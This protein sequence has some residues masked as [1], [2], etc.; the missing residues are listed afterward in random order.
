MKYENSNRKDEE[1]MKNPILAG[2]LCVLAAGIL[3]VYGGG[4]FYYQSHFVK[5][6]V[7]DQVDVSG[8]TIPELEEQVQEYF[9]R[10]LERKTDGTMLEEDIQGKEIGLAYSSVEPLEE[11]L[12]DQNSWLWFSRQDTVHET[13]EL[14]TY[15]QAALENEVR[16]L[17][18]F[19]SD[20][21]AAPTDAHISD[22]IS[23]TG[24]EIVAETQGNELNWQSTYEAIKGAVESLEEQVDLD[25][26]GCYETPEITSENEQLKSTL[27]KLQRYAGI[28]ITYTFG[29]TKEV[30]DGA[31]ISS[32]LQVDG[33]EVELDQ[34]QV[35]EYVAILR[36]RYDTIF[37]SRTFKTSYGT[38]ITIDQGDYGWWMNYGQEA[39]ELAEMIENGESG[40]RTPVYY[41]TAASYDTPDYGNTY[42]EINLTAQHLFFYKDGEL[43]LESDFV[44]GNSARGYDT[45]AGVYG[46]TYKQRNATLVGETYETPVSYWMPFNGNIGL[47]D[48]SWRSS[49]GGD[50]YKT[51]GS[52]GCINLP[53]AKAKELYEYVEKGT[54][55]ICYYLP[56][57][58]PAGTNEEPIGASEESA[59][60]N[61]QPEA[62]E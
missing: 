6:T 41:Q 10:I 42:V 9:L 43:I 45:P 34:E 48:A 3:A 62:S 46:I 5:G 26:S 17:K 52:H 31:T 39:I 29:D 32:W 1:F 60:T 50:I 59:E 24:F 2:L 13:V 28:T 58:K 61:E 56:G 53:P 37:R 51:N 47:H 20:F 49:F 35:K 23:G 4:V 16:N 54:P 7:I 22:Y 44:S 33:F 8:M 40:A 12:K 55:V 14:I 15:D 19:Q 18:G 11:I 30:L 21:A 36:K 38:E 57:T 27:E 25:A